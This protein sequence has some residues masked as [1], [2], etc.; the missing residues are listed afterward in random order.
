M[1]ARDEI[2][3]IIGHDGQPPLGR[4]PF[5]KGTVEPGG[6]PGGAAQQHR[7]L[8]HA[9]RAEQRGGKVRAFGSDAQPLGLGRK[10]AGQFHAALPALDRLV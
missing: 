4:Q 3:V 5:G 1:P 8:R 9:R 2:A 7:R 6:H 10:A